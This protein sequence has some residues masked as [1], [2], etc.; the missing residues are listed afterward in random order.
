M[1]LSHEGA[2]DVGVTMSEQETP[3]EQILLTVLITPNGQIK[4]E[5]PILNDEV[6]AYGILEKAKMLIADA[7]KQPKIVKPVGNFLQG[8][9]ENGVGK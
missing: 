9:R 3:K 7:H 1:F 6:T 5:G 8:L 2:N 4:L